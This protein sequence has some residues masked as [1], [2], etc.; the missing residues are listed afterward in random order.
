MTIVMWMKLRALTRA[1][2]RV[3]EP[4]LLLHEAA[5]QVAQCDRVAPVSGATGENP[6]CP[7]SSPRTTR[8]S[9]PVEVRDPAL[10][11]IAGWSSF[12]MSSG[13]YFSPHTSAPGIRSKASLIFANLW[14]TTASSP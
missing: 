5:E 13:A 7:P 6:M 14:S 9:V 2:R 12:G 3:V 8:S 11:P 1:G 10:D 4:G